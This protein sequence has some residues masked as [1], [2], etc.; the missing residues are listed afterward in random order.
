MLLQGLDKS[1]TPCVEPFLAAMTA[2][3]GFFWLAEGVPLVPM[4]ENVAPVTGH[5]TS[6]NLMILMWNA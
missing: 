3:N 1:D 5:M 4:T 6:P 2:R